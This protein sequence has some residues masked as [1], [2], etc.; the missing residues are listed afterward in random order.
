MQNKYMLY[1]D[2]LGLND[3]GR[4]ST[5]T[6][7]VMQEREAFRRHRT[8]AGVS[9]D[10]N[11]D[12]SLTTCRHGFTRISTSVTSHANIWIMASIKEDT[13]VGTA[14]IWAQILGLKNETDTEVLQSCILSTDQ[15]GAT[16]QNE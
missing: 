15:Q 12:G 11:S 8:S 5:Q 4:D 9:T 6:W 3:T 13:S 14:L 10:L 2:P 16:P 7:Q 1:P